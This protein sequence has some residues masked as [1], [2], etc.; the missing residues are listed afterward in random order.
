MAIIIDGRKLSGK[1]LKKI[2]KE[3]KKKQLKL[4]L[5]VILVGGDLISKLYI[6]EKR[7]ACANVGIDFELFK[8][9]FKIKELELKKEIKK[10]VKDPKNSGVIIQLPLDKRFK[11]QEILDIIPSN[12]DIDVLSSAN[13]SEFYGGTLSILP[14]VVSGIRH[15]L[16]EYNISIKNK[17][18]VL[19]GVGRLV[20]WPLSLWLLKEGAS[21]SVADKTTKNISSLTKKAD[22]I[23]SG[24]GK[25][26]LI[27]GKMVKKG[28]VVI[29]AG[30]SSLPRVRGKLKEGGMSRSKGDVDFESVSKKAGYITPVPGGVGPMTVA[31]LL[32]NLLKIKK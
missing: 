19:V 16:K 11:T 32:E 18:I 17:K 26:N 5:A 24:T 31:C 9:P 28:V 29:D 22:I 23:I 14:P 8:F 4:K 1:I 27:T 7:F 6:Q 13:I 30:A 15:L 20:G 21:F 2:E 3:I 25:P 10:I 12:K